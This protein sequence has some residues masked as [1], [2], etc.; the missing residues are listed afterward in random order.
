MK[1][2][3]ILSNEDYLKTLKKNLQGIKEVTQKYK[4]DWVFVTSGYEGTGK[5]TLTLQEA[6]ILNKNFSPSRNCAWTIKDFI[7][8][9]KKFMKSPGEVIFLDESSSMF[10]SKE[11]SQKTNIILVKIFISNRSF[12]LFHF[13]NIPNFYWLEKYIREFRIR[14]LSYT[15]FDW[16]NPDR[17]M[18]AFYTKRDYTRIL[19]DK[20]AR[21]YVI[22]SDLFLSKYKPSFVEE[23]S[24][25]DE[26]EPFWKEYMEGKE[27]FQEDLL[28]E[29]LEE[30]I[31]LEERKKI[32]FNEKM[33]AEEFL[34]WLASHYRI[35]R[36]ALL[37]FN[38]DEVTKNWHIK[39]E[40]FI[41]K[42]HELED[43]GYLVRIA[44]TRY[45]LTEKGLQIVNQEGIEGNKELTKEFLEEG[46]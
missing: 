15:F 23:F 18:F 37:K 39:D 9:N 5:S 2:D 28:D 25:I 12:R 43:L 6:L 7:L 10:L 35:Y 19:L 46:M 3:E 13:L 36:S 31:K 44:K 38:T 16:T 24:H 11:S 45:K 22:D 8:L 21:V 32:G 29:A 14:S 26:S 40:V 42:L 34:K 17:R 4:Q 27:G 20:R 1:I 33:S 30:A 41:D